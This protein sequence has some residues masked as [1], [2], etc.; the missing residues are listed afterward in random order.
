MDSKAVPALALQEDLP[1][2]QE[3]RHRVRL[4]IQEIPHAAR[5]VLPIEI[6]H[7]AR[8]AML[9]GARREVLLAVSIVHGVHL[10]IRGIPH[11]ETLL[12]LRTGAHRQGT[13]HLEMRLALSAIQAPGGRLPEQ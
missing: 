2:T 11:R 1:A 5:L 13:P 4:V 12:A 3:T 7:E 6:P 9:I 8:P 10:A